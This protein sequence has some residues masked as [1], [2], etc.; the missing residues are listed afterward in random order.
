VARSAESVRG[1]RP[2]AST[3]VGAE[4]RRAASLLERQHHPTGHGAT[5]IEAL[6]HT[7][8]RFQ[9]SLRGP[10]AR[11][12]V[13]RDADRRPATA[14]R[15]M[16]GERATSTR[17]ML[18]RVPTPRTR[19]GC[20]QTRM[21]RRVQRKDRRPGWS[22]V[23]GST[24]RPL[25]PNFRDRHKAEVRLRRKPSTHLGKRV[26]GCLHLKPVLWAQRSVCHARVRDRRTPSESRTW[27]TRWMVS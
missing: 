1:G 7:T 4:G 26:P 11:A 2:P 20:S 13:R 5:Q 18:H 23:D 9:G 15:Y 24:L 21:V 16:R 19:S 22:P 6:V 8:V 27:R 10:R 12:G 17:I 14:S 25:P 3:E